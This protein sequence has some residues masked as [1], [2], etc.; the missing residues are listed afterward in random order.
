LRRVHQLAARDALHHP[1]TGV[2]QA[3]VAR[4]DQRAIVG[5][6]RDADVEG[7]HTVAALYEPVTAARQHGAA[8][9]R[10]LERPAGDADDPATAE[11][12]VAEVVHLGIHRDLVEELA[13]DTRR[14][15]R[16][17]VRPPTTRR[18]TKSAISCAHS[19]PSGMAFVRKTKPWIC[20]GYS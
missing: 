20:P 5:A 14:C 13:P 15:G 8:Q 19:R 17:D 16:H 3:G 10:F 18:R 9:P 7:A 1:R 12:G 6:E 11:W 2:E 4:E